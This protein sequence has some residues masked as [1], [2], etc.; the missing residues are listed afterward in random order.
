MREKRIDTAL[1]GVRTNGDKARTA[2]ETAQGELTVA[3]TDQASQERGLIKL[4]RLRDAENLAVAE[5]RLQEA[6]CRSLFASIEVEAE[7]E[8][9]ATLQRVIDCQDGW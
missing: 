1:V 6:T 5:S 2:V 7:R 9:D 4:R 3:M 8:P